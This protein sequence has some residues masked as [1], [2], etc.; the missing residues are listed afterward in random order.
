[1]LTPLAIYLLGFN[2]V[3][4]ASAVI[5]MSVVFVV[6]FVKRYIELKLFKIIFYPFLSTILMGIIIY[7][8][9]PIFATNLLGVVF[10]M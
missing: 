2:G 10:I 1:V 7:I 9:S 4:I 6:Y 3:A 8:L 5:S